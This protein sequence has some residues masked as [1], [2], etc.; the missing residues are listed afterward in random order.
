[1]FMSSCFLVIS[2]LLQI[3]LMCL[4]GQQTMSEYSILPMQLYKSDWPEMISNLK[5]T[6]PKNMKMVLII[7]MQTLIM[8]TQILIGKVFPLSLPTF[9]SVIVSLKI[10]C[11]LFGKSFIQNGIWYFLDNNC[12][13]ST[14]C[15]REVIKEIYFFYIFPHIA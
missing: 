1:M 12:G 9:T 8:D 7:F 15:H 3:F 11:I 13:L 5:L 10:N 2:Y 4:F 14:P 6:N